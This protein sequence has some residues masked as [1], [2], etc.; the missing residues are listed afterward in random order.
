MNDY[1]ISIL[2][3]RNV[4]GMLRMMRLSNFALLCQNTNT[5]L[6]KML[7]LVSR[8]SNHLK[9]IKADSFF[10]ETIYSINSNIIQFSFNTLPKNFNQKIL[11]ESINLSSRNHE[12]NIYSCFHFCRFC[13]HVDDTSLCLTNR[14]YSLPP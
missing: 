3:H 12:A 2:G 10:H 7:F 8:R 5:V 9:I 13:H 1:S 11:L 4:M 14:E 6:T